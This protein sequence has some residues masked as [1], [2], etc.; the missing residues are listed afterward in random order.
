METTTP[1]RLFKFQRVKLV[2]ALMVVTAVLF[3]IPAMSWAQNSP[4][5]AVANAN[6]TSGF[7]P[8]TVQFDGSQSY[9]PEGGPLTYR[10]DFND[11][12][13]F[14]TEESPIH[15]YQFAGP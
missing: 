6:M 5:V 12:T 7:L 15:T 10:W 11:G 13:P 9:D 1:K 14:S 8:L 3:S 4:P 2:A